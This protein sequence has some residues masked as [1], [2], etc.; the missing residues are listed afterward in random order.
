MN[1]CIQLEQALKQALGAAAVERAKVKVE[2]QKQRE[3]KEQK[4]KEDISR[5][6][7][8][9]EEKLRQGKTLTN[10]DILVMQASDSDEVSNTR[11]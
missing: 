4:Q 11:K 1:E 7:E 8:H 3:L 2:R 6:K 10:D 9:V 5:K